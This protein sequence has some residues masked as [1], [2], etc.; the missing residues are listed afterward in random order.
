[1]G[2]GDWWSG[3]NT[4]TRLT[5]HQSPEPTGLNPPSLPP[6]PYGVVGEAGGGDGGVVGVPPGAGVVG[7]VAGGVV[8]PG[9]VAPGVVVSGVAG[10]VGEAVPSA[11]AAGAVASTGTAGV[12]GNSGASLE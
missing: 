12:G 10:A 11:G 5:N 6:N 4:A 3:A 1:M 2:T 8:A 9:V 7:G